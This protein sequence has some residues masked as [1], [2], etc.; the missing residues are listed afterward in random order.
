M[1]LVQKLQKVMEEVSTVQKDGFNEFHKYKYAK[2]AD[3]V[4]AVRPAMI[5]HG[6][7]ILPEI[8]DTRKEGDLTT[9]TMKF[10]ILNADN[11]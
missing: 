4:R 7:V 2:E 6:V 8:T 5:K 3:Y 1:N 9:I 10:T 11:P